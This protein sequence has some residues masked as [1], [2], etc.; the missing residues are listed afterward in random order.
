MHMISKC[1]LKVSGSL[2]AYEGQSR[3]KPA[4][5]GLEH[6]ETTLQVATA[7]DCESSSAK[8]FG[9]AASR[10]RDLPTP[11]LCYSCLLSINIYIDIYQAIVVRSWPFHCMQ[12]CFF[13]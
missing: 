3:V 7:K 9:S 13:L 1:H 8:A 5:C 4:T 12:K 11:P 6:R 2:T 10:A